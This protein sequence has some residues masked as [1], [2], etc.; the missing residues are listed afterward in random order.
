MLV[1]GRDTLAAP[2]GLCAPT[3]HGSP[4]PPLS[5]HDLDAVCEGAHDSGVGSAWLPTPERAAVTRMRTALLRRRT[6][7]GHLR[8]R[9]ILA[10]LLGCA[11]QDVVLQARPCTTCGGPH[12]KPE[13]IAPGGRLHLNVSHSGRFLALALCAHGEVGVDVEDRAE[14]RGLPDPAG[15]LT[16]QERRR[17]QADAPPTDEALLQAWVAKESVLKATGEGL[18]RSLLDASVVDETELQRWAPRMAVQRLDPT[19]PPQWTGA[20]AGVALGSVR[21]AV[22]PVVVGPGQST[23]ARPDQ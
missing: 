15:W 22:H 11:P 21:L 9:A 13:L 2:V 5:G 1:A 17:L 16:A 6:L 4:L 18:N 3:D 8:R 14:L 19:G 20:V 12:G 7:I 10:E 23:P